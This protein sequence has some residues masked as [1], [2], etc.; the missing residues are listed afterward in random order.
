MHAPAPLQHS[1]TSTMVL[2]LPLWAPAW[3]ISTAILYPVGLDVLTDASAGLFL[4][5]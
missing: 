3:I 5:A 4:V 1:V 2:L